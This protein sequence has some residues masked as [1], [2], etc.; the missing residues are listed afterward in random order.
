[1]ALKTDLDK[2][3]VQELVDLFRHGQ[4]NLSPAFQRK[5]VWT[6]TDRRL[7]V[8]SLFDNIPLPS[9]YLYRRVGHGGKPVYDVV[10]GKQRIESLF[11]FIGFG[12]VHQKSDP[13]R[14][15]RSFSDDETPE[16]WSWKELDNHQ[17]HEFLTAQIPTIVVGGELSEIIELFV[18]INATGKKLTSQEKRHAHYF[19]SPVLKAARSTADS[20]APKLTKAGVLSPSQ[21]QRMKHVELI[22]ELLLAIHAG[23]PLHKKKKID[24]VIKG[25]GLTESEVSKSVTALKS[26]VNLAF[27]ILPDLKTTRF[28]RL[29]DFYTLVLL[30]H[31]YKDEGLSITAHN[32]TRNE[33]AGSLLREFGASVDT[34]SELLARGKP[35]KTSDEP[36][37]DY[38][39]TVK[40]G[41]DSKPQR[42]KREKALRVV[43][44]GVF[45][46]LDTSRTFNATQRRILWHASDTKVCHFGFCR[47]PIDKWEDLAID[48]VQAFIK[49][50][51]TK[52]SN[53]GL[54]HKWCNSKAG[55]KKR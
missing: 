55:A 3:T 51:P 50:G 46:T 41:T 19:T 15:K 30:L 8:N 25:D 36:F 43:L 39:M 24:E 5:S 21:I 29:A 33:V 28:H 44:D 14:V 45:D 54:A 16:W 53:A 17:R 10:D 9:V 52:L 31:R 26:A 7:L 32:S 35:I 6:L 40:E 38:L 20:L 2:K 12:P 1:M 11:A 42:D 47:K 37:R 49:G 22:T 18:R 48:H 4:L 34:V 23:M 27:V 13:L